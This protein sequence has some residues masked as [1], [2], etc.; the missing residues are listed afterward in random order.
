[1]VLSNYI[2]VSIDGHI[3][4]MAETKISVETSSKKRASQDL[5]GSRCALASVLLLALGEREVDA[6]Q[7]GDN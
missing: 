5:T 7:S 2:F 4:T 3:Q 6:N 1:L